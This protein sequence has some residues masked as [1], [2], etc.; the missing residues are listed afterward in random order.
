[1]SVYHQVPKSN[2][3]NVLC[4][5][6]VIRGGSVGKNMIHMWCAQFST[7][8]LGLTGKLTI[9]TADRRGNE[10]NRETRN[11]PT[12]TD[13]SPHHGNAF[14]EAAFLNVLLWTKKT[15][16]FC[17]V[18]SEGN[19]KTQPA[20]GALDQLVLILALDQTFSLRLLWDTLLEENVNVFQGVSL[21]SSPFWPKTGA[22]LGSFPHIYG[23]ICWSTPIKRTQ[24]D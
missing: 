1:M 24:A 16:L 20:V 4:G 17:C 18:C 5:C 2:F 8:P 10:K 3:P 6:C 13:G 19:S 12:W 21:N 22:R 7:I 9:R 23:L 14:W 15:F 11:R